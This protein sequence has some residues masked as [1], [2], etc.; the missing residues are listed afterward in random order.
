MAVNIDFPQKIEN[1]YTSFNDL[2]NLQKELNGVIF[3]DVEIDFKNTTFIVANL[4]AVMGAI[5]D[6]VDAFTNVTFSNFRDPVKIILQK[7]DFLSNY[8]YHKI[9]DNCSTTI[10]Y[11]KFKAKETQPFYEYINNELFSKNDFPNMS[12]GFRKEVATS[13]LE[14][15]VNADIHGH[16]DYVYTC[17][18]YFPYKGDLYFTLVNIG[19]TIR[20]NVAEFCNNQNVKGSQAI[21]WAVRKDTTTKVGVPGGLGLDT[22][23]TF[24]KKNKGSIQ[25]ISD[26]GYWQEN[27]CDTMTKDFINSF[28]GTIV[29]FKIKMDDTQDYSTNDELID[30]LFN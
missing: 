25:I 12:Q 20:Q 10:G 26:D 18:Q 16:C 14:I 30:D 7:N 23:R 4:S 8:G 9:P 5:F 17:G 6:N 13:L 29:N 24:I 22:V 21:N 28:N 3:E 27:F 19:K 2:I 11:K 15:F 1:Q